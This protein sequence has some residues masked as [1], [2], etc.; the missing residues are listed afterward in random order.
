[1]GAGASNTLH[2]ATW[3]DLT[4]AAHYYGISTNHKSYQELK[5]IIAKKKKEELHAVTTGNEEY[6][7]R[8]Y[9]TRLTKQE[10]DIRKHEQFEQ[11]LKKQNEEN[12]Q[13]AVAKAKRE[14][15]KQTLDDILSGK[16]YLNVSTTDKSK[17]DSILFNAYM[18]IKQMKRPN[19]ELFIDDIKIHQARVNSGMQELSDTNPAIRDRVAA[20]IKTLET[21]KSIVGGRRK[22]KRSKRTRKQKQTRRSK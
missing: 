9:Q 21:L 7:P 8:L 2:N 19:S 13:Q 1:M 15:D 16:E 12:K 11:S 5:T 22:S 14:K 20:S 3:E 4:A 17:I 6:R 18:I 10:N